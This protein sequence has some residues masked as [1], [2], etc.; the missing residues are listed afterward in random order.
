MNLKAIELEKV[1][2]TELVGKDAGYSIYAFS[3]VVLKVIRLLA[4]EAGLNEND[5]SYKQEGSTNGIYLTYK[6]V[7]FGDASFQKQKGK[8]H[9]GHYD[10]TFKKA[11]VNLWCE[12]RTSYYRGLDFQGMLDKI[13]EDKNIAAN[14]EAKKLEQAKE[15]FQIIKDKLGCDDYGARSFIDF[16]NKKKYSISQ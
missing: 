3:S 6:G 9:Y 11:F 15:I 1:L 10:W 4:K 5:F 16:L 2:N 12:D 8:Y 14:N 7:S 13:D